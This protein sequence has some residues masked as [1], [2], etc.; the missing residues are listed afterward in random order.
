MRM[1]DLADQDFFNS[2]ICPVGSKSLLS[3]QKLSK[4]LYPNGSYW[5][6]NS[7]SIDRICNIIHYNCVVGQ[8]ER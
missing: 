4:D 6:E 2:I 5:Y 8:D 3:M 7:P 1:G